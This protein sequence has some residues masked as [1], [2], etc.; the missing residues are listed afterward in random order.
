M[1]VLWGIAIADTKCSWKR[2]STAVSTFSTLRATSSISVLAT[3]ESN[4]IIAPTP[5]AL[6][7]D[8]TWSSWQSGIIPRIIA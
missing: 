2:G 3:P 5:A 1:A 7:A 8:E 6:P 4:A